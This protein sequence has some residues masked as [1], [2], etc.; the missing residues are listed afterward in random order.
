[1]DSYTSARNPT[2]DICKHEIRYIIMVR[3]RYLCWVAHDN[4]PPKTDRRSLAFRLITNMMSSHLG[5]V[6]R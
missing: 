6:P 4:P 5:E 2:D 1:M 3:L